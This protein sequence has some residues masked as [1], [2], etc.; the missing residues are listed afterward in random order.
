[1]ITLQTVLEQLTGEGIVNALLATLAENFEDF[2][3][4]QRQYDAA[5]EL[6]ESELGNSAK[7]AIQEEV[8]AI[9]RQTISNLL[10]SGFLGLKANLDHFIDPV[11]RNFL[12]TDFERFLRV[13]T[14][15]NLPE[16]RSEQQV[17]S[18]CVAS[19]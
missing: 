17:R 7:P 14:A 11:S 3:Q 4:E 1:M 10:F 16:Y 6:L 5:I 13:Q 2:A 9:R 8:E 12:D 19:W 15:C 18:Q